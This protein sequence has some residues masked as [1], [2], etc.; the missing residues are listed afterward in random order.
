MVPFTKCFLSHSLPH[1]HTQNSYWKFQNSVL[2]MCF[3]Q[4]HFTTVY[5]PKKWER[6]NINTKYISSECSIY[7]K[8]TIYVA[9]I[10]DIFIR[11]TKNNISRY[12]NMFASVQCLRLFIR[13]N[14]MQRVEA[15]LQSRAKIYENKNKKKYVY[16]RINIELSRTK[17]QRS[18]AKKKK[19]TN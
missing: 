12:Y 4:H 2:A 1:N 15:N 11:T 9:Y 19:R 8:Y 5:S 18:K 7:Y 16:F 6:K 17:M 14:L 10:N 3:E 13:L